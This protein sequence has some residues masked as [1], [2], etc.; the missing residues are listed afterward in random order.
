[1]KSKTW[2]SG[3]ASGVSLEPE[4]PVIRPFAHEGG[5]IDQLSHAT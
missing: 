4:A 5:G 2:S 3:P 1:M